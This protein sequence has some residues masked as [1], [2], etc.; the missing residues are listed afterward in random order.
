MIDTLLTPL[1]EQV[2][3][4][5]LASTVRVDGFLARTG[6]Q[7]L[8]EY[9]EGMLTAVRPRAAMNAGSSTSREGLTPSGA[10]ATKE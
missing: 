7:R 1:A 4:R 10:D 6:D 3:A 2:A 5:E 8:R 9:N